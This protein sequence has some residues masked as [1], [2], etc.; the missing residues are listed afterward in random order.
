MLI[1]ITL[2]D[3]ITD[4]ETFLIEV[5]SPKATG[6]VITEIIK[7]L[8]DESFDAPPAAYVRGRDWTKAAWTWQIDTEDRPQLMTATWRH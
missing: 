1:Q 5:T 3:G 8:D 6:E 7:R 4:P 2:E